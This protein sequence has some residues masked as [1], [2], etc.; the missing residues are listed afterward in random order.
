MMVGA[1]Q[2]ETLDPGFVLFGTRQQGV[3]VILR[4][5][6]CQQRT[7]GENKPDPNGGRNQKEALEVDRT[8]IQESTQLR[9][10]TSPHMEPSR[11]KEERKT[12]E[13][14]TPRN[15]NRHGKDEQ[16]LDGIRKEGSGQSGLEN[17]GRRPMLH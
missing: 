16:E 8:H 4:E 15:E 6:D 11:P 5:L 14:I 10:K 17:A 13:H 1:S 2:Q 3:P 7:V 9:H 12:K